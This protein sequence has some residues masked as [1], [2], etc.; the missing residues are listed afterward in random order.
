MPSGTFLPPGITTSNV[1]ISTGG[2]DN[3]VL[4]AV[5]G[6]TAQGEAN[7]TFDGST[8]TVIGALT[9]GVN[10]TG[11]DVKFFGATSG[12]YTL[13]DEDQNYLQFSDNGSNAGAKAVFGTGADLQIFHDHTNSYIDNSTGLLIIGCDSEVRIT[14]G[15]AAEF[16]ATFVPDGAVN[17][18]HSGDGPKFYTA[19]AGAVIDG[20]LTIAGA[21]PS[22]TI[23]DGDAEDTAIYF[24][25]G[26]SNTIDG[27]SRDTDWVLARDNTYYSFTLSHG[28]TVNTLGAAQR[29]SFYPTRA[30]DY[31]ARMMGGHIS[32]ADAQTMY[33]FGVGY[34]LTSAERTTDTTIYWYSHAVIGSGAGGSVTTHGE[35]QT[36]PIITSLYVDEPNISIGSGGA[37]SDTVTAA[38]SLYIENAPTEATNNY[39]LWVDSGASRF[40]GLVGI[41]TGILEDDLIVEL[42][43]KDTGGA[44]IIAATAANDSSSELLLGDVDDINI[45]RIRSVHSSNDLT[46]ETN[47]VEKMRLSSG[48]ILF[49]NDTANTAMTQGLTINQ[50][51]NDDPIFELKSSDINHGLLGYSGVTTETDTFYSISKVSGSAGGA[52][53][54]AYCE[55]GASN[56]VYRVWASGG[57]ANTDQT[58]TGAGLIDFIAMEHDGSN[59]RANIESGGNVLSVKAYSGGSFKTRFLI[60]ENGDIHADGTLS[61]YDSFDDAHLVRALDIARGSK[62]VV[63]GEWDKFIK[64]G[65]DKLVELGILGDTVEN[66]GLI[67]VTGLQRLHN[68][69]IWQGYTRQMELQERVHELETRL[70]ALEGGK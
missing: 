58:N 30:K 37:G 18:Y 12:L 49:L 67:N 34:D 48:G 44:A 19:A 26:T 35:S 47:N 10:D 29:I 11:H 57:S 70:L 64:Y 39:A 53:I 38:T 9:V 23:G 1:K 63:K 32:V 51:A 25:G 24:G 2:S 5:D 28:D 43:V 3:Q 62:D 13:W 20:N 69:A 61:A 42:E 66:G 45:Q 60:E 17:L 4:T 41:G 7:L 15:A 16:M 55:D 59:G 6:E 27:S 8:L 21:T 56:I 54:N 50:G 14:K 68:G 46:F 40:D 65:E 36:I 52:E 31:A 33:G 22:L